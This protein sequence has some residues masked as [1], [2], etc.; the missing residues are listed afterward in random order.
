MRERRTSG[1]EGGGAEALPTPISHSSAART[2]GSLA[3]FVTNRVPVAGNSHFISLA[4][5]RVFA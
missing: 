4:G 1:S 2:A 3:T 5:G